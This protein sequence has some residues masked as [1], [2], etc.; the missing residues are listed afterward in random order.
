MGIP[1]MDRHPS[2]MPQVK[3]KGPGHSCSSTKFTLMQ[4]A[5]TPG[6]KFPFIMEDGDAVNPTGAILT[7]S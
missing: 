6:N 5:G 2:G 1:A 7:G 3:S 4:V